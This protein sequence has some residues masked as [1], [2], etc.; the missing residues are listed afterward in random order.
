MFKT[1]LRP[2]FLEHFCSFCSL[3]HRLCC[4]HM[5]CWQSDADRRTF[6]SWLMNCLHDD[7]C[8]AIHIWSHSLFPLSLSFNC[9]S[10]SECIRYRWNWIEEHHS[11][12][13]KMFLSCRPSVRLLVEGSVWAVRGRKP[14]IVCF[15]VQSVIEPHS[16]RRSVL[17][18]ANRS[19]LIQSS[20]A[21]NSLLK[22]N[23]E[24]YYV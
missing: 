8:G 6:I 7:L 24:A 3:C 2:W 20:K 14:Q 9:P 17:E 15:R 13:L 22:A 5:K 10:T 18:T 4:W 23:F 1:W 11:N 16:F 12:L 21:W 19:L